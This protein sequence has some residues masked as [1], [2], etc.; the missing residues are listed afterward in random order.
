MSGLALILLRRGFTVSGSDAAHSELTAQLEQEGCTIFYEQTAK[1]ITP[2][3]DLI[4]YTAAMKKS[5]PEM[6]AAISSGI[7]MLTRAQLLG[8]IMANYPVAINVAGTHG[9][10]TTTSMLSC[11]MM[12]ACKD[13]T[14]SI[15]GIL[16]AIGGNVRIGNSEYFI[17]EACEYTNS[18]LSFKPTMDIILNVCEDHLDFFKDINDIRNSFLKFTQLLPNDGTLIIN[19]DIEDY[20]FFCHGSFKVITVGSDPA[21]SNYSAEDITYDEFGCPSYTLL[22]DGK[23]T[24]KIKLC[25]P[26]LH[27]VYNSL[28][29][30]AAALCLGITVKECAKGLTE[31]AGTKRRFEH[32]GSFNGVTVIDDYAHHPD[33]I[34]ATLNSALR[35][36]HKKIWCVFQPHT[37]SRTK[38]LFKEFGEALALADTVVLADIYAARETDTLGIS[39]ADL[40]EE[41][42][43]HN[44]NCYYFSSFEEIE[45]FLLKNCF[46]GDLLITM[47]AG[48][49]YKIA[50]DIIE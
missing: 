22:V 39:S 21:K 11:I 50:E 28:A 41:I 43:K 2:N 6:A 1:N 5:N 17:T 46:N 8:E 12:S 16:D 9:K 23:A 10:T 42:K 29:A 18:F 19:S 15:G 4:V 31:F 25:V 38:L 30:I 48:N 35:Y 26:G 40:A 44:R 13:P 24:Q 7:P 34:R 27:N 37:Y 32:K 36:P 14:I 3:I 33:E 45:K 47:G 20:E 49:V